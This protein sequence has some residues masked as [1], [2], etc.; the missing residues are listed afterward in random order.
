MSVLRDEV[1]KAIRTTLEGI[2]SPLNADSDYVV[3]ELTDAA[4]R[5]V[6]EPLLNLIVDCEPPDMGV[7]A[8]V[9]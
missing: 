5:A 1:R 7:P 3:E 8:V 6:Q 9:L 2:P 4:L